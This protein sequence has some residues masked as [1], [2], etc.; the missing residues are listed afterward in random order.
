MKTKHGLPE[1]VIFCKRCLMSNQRPS[2]SPELR[3]TSSDIKTAGFSDDG[4]CDACN[5]YDFKKG[6][7]W[8]DREKQYCS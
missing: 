7:D 6:M 5:Y 8:E 2:S 4:I 3:K 1:K